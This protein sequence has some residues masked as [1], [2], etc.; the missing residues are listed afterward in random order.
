MSKTVSE[1]VGLLHGKLA[2]VTGAARGIGR[3]TAVA[4]ANEG[5]DVMGIGIC[6]SVPA[7]RRQ[8][9]RKEDLDET[10]RQVEATGR[11]WLGLVVDQRDMSALRAAAAQVEREI[12]GVD[13]LFANA[14][15]QA[16]KSLLEM[17]DADWQVQI[18][19]NLTGTANAIRAF[20]PYLAKRKSG[21]SSSLPPRRGGTE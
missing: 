17:D 11:L 13:I 2:V 15:I 14:G 10:G 16:F 18:D 5:A 3:A 4:F 6:A 1:Q 20:G 8:A 12:R 9:G 21:A 19:N 7:I